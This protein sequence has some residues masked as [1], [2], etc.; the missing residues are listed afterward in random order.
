LLGTRYGR[1]FNFDYIFDGKTYTLFFRHDRGRKHSIYYEEAAKALLS[2]L[3]I[4][5]E[6]SLTDSLVTVTFPASQVRDS[7]S[8][9]EP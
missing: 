9:Q 3:G 4:K 1:L 8:S 6:I 5:P 7:G 2:R